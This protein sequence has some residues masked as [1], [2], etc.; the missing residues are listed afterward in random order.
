MSL[1]CCSRCNGITL[2][3]KPTMIGERNVH[4]LQPD[5]Q[6][7]LTDVFESNL[8]LTQSSS[9]HPSLI[10]HDAT[11]DKKWFDYSESDWARS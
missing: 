5:A 4:P 1:S 6:S 11:T 3:D 10:I 7:K 9:D 2:Q 8:V